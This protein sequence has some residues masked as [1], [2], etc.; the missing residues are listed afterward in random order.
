MSPSTLAPADH[1]TADHAAANHEHAAARLKL[2]RASARLLAV[3]SSKREG[4]TSPTDVETAAHAEACKRAVQHLRQLGERVI[5]TIMS[6]P[7]DDIHK[8]RIALGPVVALSVQ[9]LDLVP[10]YQRPRRK[11]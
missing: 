6:V 9:S 10:A 4:N 8:H 1:V 5:E 2:L 7:S 11:G 3:E